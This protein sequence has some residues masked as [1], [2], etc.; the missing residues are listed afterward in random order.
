ME[1]GKKEI[2]ACPCGIP[3]G[4]LVR[5]DSICGLRSS[6][7]EFGMKKEPKL[8]R[9]QVHFT[10][11]FINAS[12]RLTLSGILRFDEDSPNAKRSCV[13][14]FF[15]DCEDKSG[16][17][18]KR[19]RRYDITPAIAADIVEAMQVLARFEHDRPPEISRERFRESAGEF[20]VSLKQT[21]DKTFFVLH[22]ASGGW[23]F[24]TDDRQGLFEAFCNAAR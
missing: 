12:D 24:E 5:I 6:A 1:A 19:I 13:L 3:G 23:K 9:E 17:L 21:P 18:V 7:T 14:E 11:R 10:S 16:E 22:S 2:A 8:W 15:G 4:R 20:L